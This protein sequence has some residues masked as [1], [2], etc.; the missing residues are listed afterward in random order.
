[1]IYRIILPE[2]AQNIYPEYPR[3]KDGD[4][5][6]EELAAFNA[7]GYNIYFF[8]NYPSQFTEGQTV[9][10]AHVDTFDWVFVDMDLKDGKYSSKDDFLTV[11]GAA[12]I[13]PTY[14]VDS[15]NG[16]HV[17]WRVTD[18][19][20]L[21]YLRLQRRLMRRLDTDPAVAKICQIMRLPGTLNMK[22]QNHP[23]ECEYIFYD[24]ST[25]Y[26]CEELDAKLP[27]IRVDDEAYCVAHHN[28]TYNLIET[29]PIDTALPPKFGEFIRTN[30]EAKDLWVNPH[31]D[32]SAADFRLGHLMFAHGFTKEEASSV[33]V[34]TSKASTRAPIHRASYAQNIVDKIWTYEVEPEKVQLSRSVKD[35]LSRSGDTLKGTRFPGPKYLDA[36]EHGFRLGQVIGLVAGSGV[37]KTAMA[38]NMFMEFVKKNPDY[39]HFFIPLEQPANEIADRWRTM[40]G[41]ATFLHDK[42]EVISNYA[43]DGSYRNLSFDEIRDYIVEYQN[44]TGKKAGCVVIDHIGALR[45]KG[46]KNGENQDLMDICHQM[47]AFAVKTNTLLVM[48]SQAPRQKAGIGDLELD[49][50]AAYGTVFFESY[51]DYLITIWQPLKRC[52]AE[53]GCPT[54]TAFKFCKIRHKKVNVDLIKEDVCYRLLFDPKTELMRELTQDEEKSFAFFLNKAT[55]LRKA[56]KK[57]DLVHYKSMPWSEKT[58]DGREVNRH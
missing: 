43:D 52:Y 26:T 10:G 17:Y 21:S 42:V 57:T 2:W 53:D 48:Q 55:N 24:E 33:L 29:K 56:D 46:A 11:L 15:G 6:P 12:N 3:A 32:R 5:T 47:K 38:L 19:D 27:P 41:D 25:K 31:E 7:E 37:G 30:K 1:M 28:K 14:I 18:L 16:I 54:V 45:K 49:K 34:N 36:T 35:I 13:P 9:A 4:F 23:K 50:D 58:D 40:C 22:E 44:K 20:A 8:P 51:C 39:V